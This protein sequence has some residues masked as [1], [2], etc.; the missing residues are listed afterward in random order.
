MKSFTP[1]EVV[2]LSRGLQRAGLVDSGELA[3][4][5]ARE[6]AARTGDYYWSAADDEVSA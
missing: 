1:E 6:V 2:A 3:D 5:V 4:A